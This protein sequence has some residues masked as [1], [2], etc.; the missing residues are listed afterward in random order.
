MITEVRHV[1]ITVQDL[2]K[3]LN[4][5]IKVLGFKIK[6]RMNEKGEYINAMLGLKKVQ[7]TT[8][9]IQAPDGGMI[10]L[11]KF[12][13]YKDKKKWSG[14][15][16][17][18]GPTHIALTVKNIENAYKKLKNKYKFNAPPQLS[19]DGYAKVTFFKGPENLH[20][21]IVQVLK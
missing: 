1:G 12:K 17:S 6:K 14:K 7:V 21:E 3:T 9:K 2:N 13:N 4:F 15:I 16:F 11:L 19:P 8:V 18:T 5:F 10:E 20:I